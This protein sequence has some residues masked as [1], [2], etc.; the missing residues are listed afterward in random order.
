M[1]MKITKRQTQ[2]HFDFTRIH[3]IMKQRSARK[4]KGNAKPGKAINQN[5][6]VLI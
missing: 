2:N 3:K 5:F 6:P 4:I 1:P